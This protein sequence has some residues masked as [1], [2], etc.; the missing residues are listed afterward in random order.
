MTDPMPAVLGVLAAVA[1][2]LWWLR[3]KG[4]VRFFRPRVRSRARRLESIERLAL[5]P[6]HTLH[7]V[8]LDDRTIL[9]AQSPSGL[10]VLDGAGTPALRA[11]A[12][13]A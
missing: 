10:A 2:A 12:E 7:L 1:A 11:A 13:H 5:S 3:K 6:H 8:R 9:V 4:A